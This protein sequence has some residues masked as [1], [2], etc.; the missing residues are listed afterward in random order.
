MAA[1]KPRDPVEEGAVGLPFLGW[2]AGVTER[3]NRSMQ[4][5]QPGK[6]APL[7]FHTHVV[8]VWCS[9]HTAWQAS[10]PSVPYTCECVV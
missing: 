4:Y 6:P 8:S 3:M 9:V 10:A 7:V 1:R 5:T 2:L